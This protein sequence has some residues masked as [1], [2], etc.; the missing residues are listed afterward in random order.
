MV[1]GR[2]GVAG[3]VAG[4][5]AGV[6]S[7]LLA[8][9][10]VAH[11]LS[12]DVPEPLLEAT[13]LP[14]LLTAAGEPVEL[15]YDV[16]CSAGDETHAGSC[17]AAGTLYV[18]GASS[19]RFEAI[20]LH[21]APGAE[22]G[23]YVGRVPDEIAR[24]RSSFSYYAV[25][26]S[27]STGRTVT[28]P[29]GGAAA[30][31]QSLRLTGEATIGLG[32]HEFGRTRAPDGIVAEARWGAGDGEVGLEEG[33]NLA[34]IGGSAFDVDDR[35]TVHLLDE[36]NRRVLRW[37]PG[38]R[39]PEHVPLAIR[40]TLADLAV[41]DDGAMYVLETTAE[42]GP[43]VLRTFGPGGAARGAI[44][45]PERSAAV[46][47]GPAGP[48][49]LQQPS[50]QWMRAASGGRALGVLEQRRSGRSGR[51]LPDGGEVVVL[52]DGNEIRVALVRAGGVS[53]SWRL[54]SDTP[55]AEVQLAEPFGS[56]LV[57][58]VR[59]YTDQR[60]EFVVLVLDRDGVVRRFSVEAA[61][62]AETAPLSRFRLSGSSLYRLSSSPTGVSVDRFDLEVR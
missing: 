28:L 44:E 57:L 36:A 48:V 24:G 47:I 34:P 23:R 7:V 9:T 61:D 19:H 49:T 31:Q 12:P 5:L 4:A 14:M 46:R 35:G 53:R 38:S 37:T 22:E 59:V 32:S 1:M 10:A 27:E 45:M 17:D 62:W 3:V 26:T 30:P 51:P 15:R 8:G 16:Y 56:R 52:R 55:L 50:G 43:P 21:E 58:V 54:T 6:A 13:H 39:V 2:A 60:S 18:R 20:P 40:G 29:A 42:H 33:R 11:R 25:F 41:A